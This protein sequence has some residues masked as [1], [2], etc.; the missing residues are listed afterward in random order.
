MLL[1]TNISSIK[2]VDYC[3]YRSEALKAL[4]IAH[5]FRMRIVNNREHTEILVLYPL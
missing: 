2:K 3:R 4:G 5:G 1:K